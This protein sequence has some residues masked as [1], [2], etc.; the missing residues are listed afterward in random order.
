MFYTLC[1]S[2]YYFDLE[3]DR[4]ANLLLRHVEFVNI[5]G[6]QCIC[7]SYDCMILYTGKMSAKFEA[8]E[9]VSQLVTGDCEAMM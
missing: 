5:H 4:K 1:F 7:T 2:I 9:I 3:I 6:F 8:R